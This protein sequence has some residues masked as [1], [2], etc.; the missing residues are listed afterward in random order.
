MGLLLSSHRFGQAAGRSS[1]QK[2]MKV[3]EDYGQTTV[4]IGSFPGRALRAF[5]YTP[6][7]SLW[8]RILSSARSITASTS[9]KYFTSRPFAKRRL[10]S[11][12]LTQVGFRLDSSGR[13]IW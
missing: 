5:G 6:Q 7:S 10:A 1:K 8:D 13:R 9:R 3:H 2:G 11:S 4:A 12:G